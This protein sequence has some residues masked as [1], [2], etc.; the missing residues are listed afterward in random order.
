VSTGT[1]NNALA[2]PVTLTGRRR[3]SA[4]L[5]T[6]ADNVTVAGEVGFT[7]W[8]LD[9]AAVQKAEIYR[10]PVAGE[11]R[12]SSSS[13]EATFVRGAPARRPGGVSHDAVQATTRAGATWC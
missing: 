3:R 9:D 7:G 6:P 4:P 10:D 13:G 11:D 1:F 5:E 2:V 12:G 8:A